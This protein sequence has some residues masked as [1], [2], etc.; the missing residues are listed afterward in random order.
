MAAIECRRR[1]RQRSSACARA[2]A[3]CARALAHERANASAAAA[4]RALA[5]S[6][7]R[8]H[9]QYAATPATPHAAT[10]G[11]L[12]TPMAS[13]TSL[14]IHSRPSDMASAAREAPFQRPKKRGQAASRRRRRPPP[15]AD[16]LL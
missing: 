14:R 4:R 13:L 6:S 9:S 11:P 7:G 2:R 3:L 1:R 8:T 15:R 5:S 16:G 12:F 10:R